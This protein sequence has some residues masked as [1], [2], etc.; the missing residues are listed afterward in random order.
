MTA[1]LDDD[2]IIDGIEQFISELKTRP[3]K[4]IVEQYGKL[5]KVPDFDGDP[6]NDQ[7]VAGLLDKIVQESV[8]E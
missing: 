1:N 3:F 6:D 4:E 7:T 5:F 2:K 8:K